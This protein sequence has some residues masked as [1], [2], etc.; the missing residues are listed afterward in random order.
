MAAIRRVGGGGGGG[1]GGEDTK[2]RHFFSFQISPV[3]QKLNHVVSPPPPPT[4]T[5]THFKMDLRPIV[6][7]LS[8]IRDAVILE[9][10]CVPKVD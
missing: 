7:A 10:F 9:F 5:H 4:H 2:S 6:K 3:L 8:A 1:G